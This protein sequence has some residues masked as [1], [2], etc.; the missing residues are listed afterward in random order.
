M[1]SWNS[2]KKTSET[3]S[4]SAYYSNQK[5]KNNTSSMSTFQ[6]KDNSLDVRKQYVQL[7]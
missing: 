6:S 7:K 1:W 2:N 5:I 4:P 3:L